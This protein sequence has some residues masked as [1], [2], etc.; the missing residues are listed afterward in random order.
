MPQR[1][2][3]LSERCPFL[4]FAIERVTPMNIDE[5]IQ[6]LRWMRANAFPAEACYKLWREISRVTMKT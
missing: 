2:I 6:L 4:H 5:K 1:V 3:V